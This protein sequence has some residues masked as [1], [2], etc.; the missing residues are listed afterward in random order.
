MVESWSSSTGRP[1][2]SPTRTGC[3]KRRAIISSGVSL[4]CSTASGLVGGG[5]WASVGSHTLCTTKNKTANNTAIASSLPNGERPIR[6]AAQGHDPSA[7]G[8]IRL[9]SRN[10]TVFD[11]N[12]DALPSQPATCRQR[13]E[14]RDGQNSQNVPGRHEQKRILR[15][16]QR[17]E[18][19]SDAAREKAGHGAAEPRVGRC[20]IAQSDQH[21]SEYRQGQGSYAEETC[22]GGGTPQPGRPT[23][24]RR[25]GHFQAEPEQQDTQRQQQPSQAQPSFRIAELERRPKGTGRQGS[26]RQCRKADGGARPVRKRRAGCEQQQNSGKAYKRRQP[27]HGGQTG[28]SRARTCR[29]GPRLEVRCQRVNELLG[30]HERSR[31]NLALSAAR[32]RWKATYTAPRDIFSFIAVSATLAPPKPSSSTTSRCRRGRSPSRWRSG[33]A[34]LGSTGCTEWMSGKSSSGSSPR[35]RRRRT[36]ST[37]LW[38]MIARNHGAK[39]WSARQVCRLR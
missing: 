36:K 25:V 37:S 34:K 38:R 4:R 31:S 29:A 11:K 3:G 8:S 9:K 22:R 39:G 19:G 35:R 15:A 32:P 33:V 10:L 1:M 18:R 12:S 20:A 5:I 28:P 6:V 7:P 14:D 21:C 30:V 23:G 13:A 27:R 16:M 17:I 2:R 24:T 26:T